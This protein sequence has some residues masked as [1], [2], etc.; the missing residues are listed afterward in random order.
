MNQCFLVSDLHG[1]KHR[2]EALFTK[3]KQEKPAAIFLGGDLLPSFGSRGESDFL[4]DYLSQEFIALKKQLGSDYPRVF[5][6]LGNDDGKTQEENLILFMEQEKIWEYIHDK[7]A[8]FGPNKIFGY[9]YVPPTPFLNKDWER[10]DISRYTDPGCISP[11]EGWHSVEQS[12]NIIQHATIKKD[13]ID[14][15]GDMDLSK[16]IILFHTPPYQTALDRAALDG[17]MIDHVPLDVHVGSI[18]V[19]DLILERQP[20]LTLHGHVHESA[21]LTGS[22]KEQFGETTA[23]SAAH[24]GP[25]LALVRF[26]PEYPREAS[27]ELC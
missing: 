4:N 18:A 2:Y 9:A 16:S 23:L 19:K 26:D 5:L 25:E 14:L 7:S 11:E 12:I 3:I 24:D 22:W 8:Q 15:I 21:R 1:Q 10:Y 6:I 17:K 20:L 27:R 13:L